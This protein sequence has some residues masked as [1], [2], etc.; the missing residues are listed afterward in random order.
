MPEGG[1]TD[2]GNDAVPEGGSTDED[3]DAVDDVVGEGVDEE[4]DVGA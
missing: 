4:D 3:N 2:E 1:S